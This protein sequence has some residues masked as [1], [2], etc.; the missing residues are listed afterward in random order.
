[1]TAATIRRLTQLEA[2]AHAKIATNLQIEERAFPMSA[3][4][5]EF[6]DRV[7]RV[8]IS[9]GDFTNDAEHRRYHDLLLDD[10][11]AIAPHGQSGGTQS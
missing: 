1:M 6:F 8:R 9:G 7:M 11:A 10:G 5:R 2:A 3:D 4:D